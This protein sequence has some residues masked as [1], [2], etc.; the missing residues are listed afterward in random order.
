MSKAIVSPGS[1]AGAV[2]LRESG[3][4]GRHHAQNHASRR[5]LRP[6]LSVRPASRRSHGFVSALAALWAIWLVSPGGLG[7]QPELDA[8]SLERRG[9]AWAARAAEPYREAIDAW[10]KVE[11]HARRLGDERARSRSLEARVALAGL[12]LD[13]GGVDALARSGVALPVRPA[14][15]AILPGA[16]SDA[17]GL[18][19]LARFLAAAARSYPT[20][21]RAE[22]R[23]LPLIYEVLA[24]V[25]R[26]RGDIDQRQADSAYLAALRSIEAPGLEDPERLVASIRVRYKL[27]DIDSVWALAQR[28]L[29][30]SKLSAESRG[31]HY[32]RLASL[33]LL[34]GEPSLAK[35]YT[36]KARGRVAEQPARGVG[37]F[38]SPIFG[39]RVDLAAAARL[40][41]SLL[42]EY[43]WSERES[44]LA[45][46]FG[47]LSALELGECALAEEL[48]RGRDRAARDDPWLEASI[49]SRLGASRDRLGEYEGALRA[50]RQAADVSSAL[51]GTEVF[52]SRV[53]LNVARALL[54]LGK[55]AEAFETARGLIADGSLPL[56]IRLH[57]RLQLGSALYEMSREEP[58]RLAEALGAFR[59][60]RREL[61]SAS[62]EDLPG[63]VEIEV[64]AAIDTANVL[65]QQARIETSAEE[66]ARLRR[67][68]IALQDGA[69]RRAYEASL[70]ELAA[71]AS[72]NLGEL[73]LESGDRDSARSFI[74]WA[75][76][77]AGEMRLF[78]TQWRCHWYL[79]RLADAEG[80]SA[81]ADQE[82]ESAVQLIESYR[83]RILDAETKTGFMSDKLDV[84]RYLVKREMARGRAECALEYAERA[85]ARALV[86]S[87]GWRFVA[88]ADPAETALYRD[89][90]GLV[91]READLRARTE[92]D[93]LG[94]GARTVDYDALRSRLFALRARLASGES[95]PAL[96]ALADGAPASAEEIRSQLPSD[97]VL[98]EYFDRG[99]S[100][101]A[102]VV[103]EARTA[104][105]ALA[106]PHRQAK[107]MV[108]RFLRSAAADAELAVALHARLIAPLS[109]AVRGE[110]VIIVPYGALHRLPFEALRDATGYQV[111]RWEI[112]YLPS[113]SVLALLG[114]GRSAGSEA[115]EGM[116]LLGLA[117]PDT[118]YNGDGRRDKVPLAGALQEVELVSPRFSE[119]RI[120]TGAS[121]RESE[122]RRGG[123]DSDV[124]HI[125][126]HGEFYAHRPWASTLFLAPGEGGPD[127]DGLL[128]AFEVYGLDLRGKKL[129]TL[130]GCETGVPEMEAG[131][132]PAGIS[133]A[134]LHAGASSLLV[135][136]WKVE[137]RATA[138]LMQSFYAGW[139]DRKKSRSAALREAKLRLLAG[140]YSHPRQ[141]ASFVLLGNR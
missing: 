73:H 137:D 96:R 80:D 47:G 65:R 141:W 4:T 98:V 131:D 24:I 53:R 133:T 120:F 3:V 124:V 135:S 37:R 74:S 39:S 105:F 58:R 139:M 85:R 138:E 78:E 95:S 122:L 68:A 8:Q 106:L 110:R 129:V 109:E 70:P 94:I 22:E 132:D 69:L 101:V 34:R 41:V 54:A 134:F 52:R 15:L 49:L 17:A 32:A 116:R 84:F 10:V 93:F 25:R 119:H 102:F 23:D 40:F 18:E 51:P 92:R 125:A 63:R 136:L 14:S 100:L 75:L 112:S 111:A 126:C 127:D 42:S 62:A 91:G 61:E 50:W 19:W 72:S 16:S 99:D 107:E 20:S 44:A 56:E 82:L 45:G 26:A 130:S 79:G 67:E 29:D 114:S 28:P 117:D 55:P 128:R 83:A 77:R 88:L 57:A 121:A 13:A 7:A 35:V 9:D 27:R 5:A 76:E 66:A 2:D 64:R 6:G 108:D 60:A 31:R 46:Y 123:R 30:E 48:L 118:D 1:G 140:E 103:D 71:I 86:E 59:L 81:R 115:A 87:L 11:Q 33:A 43:R 89:Y 97:T 104:A 12:L 113:A 21:A 38:G 90:V 36:E